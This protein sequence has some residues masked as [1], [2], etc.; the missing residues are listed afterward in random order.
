MERGILRVVLL[1]VEEGIE[2]KEQGNLK[3]S[4]SSTSSSLVGKLGWEHAITLLI[5]SQSVHQ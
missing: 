2:T 4:G 3:G 1:T 5:K